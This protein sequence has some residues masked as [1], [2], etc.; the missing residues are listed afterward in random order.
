MTIE[1]KYDG[2][3]TGGGGNIMDK[4]NKGRIAST[5]LPL[6]GLLPSSVF[7]HNV[8]VACGLIPAVREI[9]NRYMGY[10]RQFS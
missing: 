8:G 10:D 5:A 6:W 7:R 9:F 3:A 1:S 4:W 2:C